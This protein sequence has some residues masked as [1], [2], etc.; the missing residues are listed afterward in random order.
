[1]NVFNKVTLQS[2]KKNRT[3]TIVTIIGIMLSTALVCAVTTSFA[4]VRQYAIKYFEFTDGSWHGHE[5]H[6]DYGM[7]KKIE[8]SDK[9]G[10]SGYLSYIGFAEIESENNYKP[11]LYISGFRQSSDGLMPVHLTSGRYPENSSEIILPDHL[12][13]NGGAIYK[14]GDK[15]KLAVG[16]RHP[17]IKKAREYDIIDSGSS[18]YYDGIILDA[19]E[20]LWATDVEVDDPKSDSD[21][22]EDRYETVTA[23]TLDVRETRE[24]T[25]V[26]T[27]ERPEFEQYHCPGYTALTVPDECSDDDI[28]DI[29]YSMKET[30]DIYDFMKELH[31]GGETHNELLMFIGI[32]KYGSFY[33]VVLQL[34]AIVIGLIM[35]GSIMLIYNAFSISVSERTKQFGI[36]SSIGATNKQLKKMVRFESFVVSLIGIPLGILLGIVGMWITFLAIGKRF[37]YFL[38]ESYREPMRICISPVAIIAAIIIAFITIRISAWIPS[39]RATKITAVEAIRQNTDIK[40]KKH[41]K[42]PKFIYKFFG[43]SGVLAHKYFKRSK[44]KYRSTIISLFMSIVLFVSAFSFTDYLV[45]AV[46]DSRD[47]RG[48]DYE[49]SLFQDKKYNNSEFDPNEILENIMNTEHITKAAYYHATNENVLTDESNLRPEIYTLF[50]E[51]NKYN[52]NSRLPETDKKVIPYVSIL[53]VNDEAFIEYT[54]D[55]GLNAEEFMDKNAP[56]AIIIDNCIEFNPLTERMERFKFFKGNEFD[57]STYFYDEIEGYY[58]DSI[59][60]QGNALYYSEYS[61][62]SDYED[63]KKIPYEECS[64]EAVFHVGYVTD[65]IPSF[66]NN[67]YP[68]IIYPMSVMKEVC[69]DHIDEY[70][71][72]IYN[73]AINSD[74]VLRG[75]EEVQ[76]MLK[77]DGIVNY[78]FYNYAESV[79]SDRSMVIIIKVFAYGFIVLISLIAAANVFN[80]IT[81]NI[82]LRRREFAMLKSVGMTAKGM[83]EM[84]NFECV[85]YG[86]KALFY[87]L[88]ASLGV[89]VLIY[90]A[91]NNGIDT[92][93]VIPVKAI[94]ISVL[95]VFIVVFSTMMFSMSKIKNDN[96]IDALKNENL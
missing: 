75:F 96:P 43:I 46:N 89:T 37:A 1:M 9:V 53:F 52:F 83:R 36:L 41:I 92:E 60:D 68:S 87:G 16:D 78:D 27:Y 42:T 29:Y 57:I 70:N 13:E 33:D 45:S 39:K 76:K 66:M 10:D 23:E 48:M 35:F 20:R 8:A 24:Y 56:K 59:D 88:P 81:T 64:E 11:Y 55:C 30:R 28:V 95:S 69:G 61:D 47:I 51:Y 7:Y 26:G 58:F 94:G 54:G 73:Y 49:L 40:Q 77:A 17:D 5:A 21:E 86:T 80:T 6:S 34:G 14:I 85:M 12:A 22:Y 44:K 2:L 38:D 72:N 31:L 3:R 25:V 79:E 82:S 74:D 50:E 93:F 62:G 84:L 71:C 91:V 63:I 15:L 18:A 19:E 4:S 90:R 32:S 67:D 65:K